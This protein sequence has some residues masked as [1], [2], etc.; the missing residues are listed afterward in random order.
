MDEGTYAVGEDGAEIKDENLSVRDILQQN[1]GDASVA[2]TVA[3]DDRATKD[4]EKKRI[5][6]KTSSMATT[7]DGDSDQLSIDDII[8]TK[9]VKGDQL[10][11]G[12][13][14]S[15]LKSLETESAKSSQ[16]SV[17]NIQNNTNQ[18]NSQSTATNVSGF[19]DHEPDTSFKYV[20]RS[21]GDEYI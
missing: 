2:E 11:D 13:T 1:E 17:I 12:S 8:G 19:L 9:T 3:M 16:N 14:S 7:Q 10:T 20:R 6:N 21:N 5:V 15:M 4:G 18:N